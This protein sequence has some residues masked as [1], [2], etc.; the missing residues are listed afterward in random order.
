MPLLSLSTRL[1]PDPQRSTPPSSPSKT[2]PQGPPSEPKSPPTPHKITLLGGSRGE[3]PS[4]PAASALQKLKISLTPKN[5]KKEQQSV[6]GQDEQPDSAT[7]GP[8]KRFVERSN[9]CR[10]E[11]VISVPPPH[12]P[13][14][15]TPTS[16]RSAAKPRTKSDKLAAA[17]ASSHKVTEYFPIRRSSRRPKKVLEREHQADI[18]HHLLSGNDSALDIGVRSFAEKGRGVVALRPYSKGEFVVEY[19]GDLIDVGVAKER[20]AKYSMDLATGCYM[21]YFKHKGK[22]YW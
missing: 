19:A 18:E 8:K 4:G 11:K 7:K 6:H 20:E 16:N 5:K 17:A 22:Q 15:S 14:P 10:V 9:I 13:T 12:R 3:G 1:N 2:P 21:Y